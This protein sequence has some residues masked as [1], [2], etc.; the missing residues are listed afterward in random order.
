MCG[1]HVSLIFTGKRNYPGRFIYLSPVLVY[2][3]N[4]PVNRSAGCVAVIPWTG[5]TASLPQP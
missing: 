4:P 1:Y 5:V 3:D 2:R